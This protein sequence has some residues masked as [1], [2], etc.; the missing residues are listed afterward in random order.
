MNE[1]RQFK[2]LNSISKLWDIF[3]LRGEQS[4]RRLYELYRKEKKSGE[5][6]IPENFSLC[7]FIVRDLGL[8]DDELWNEYVHKVSGV[9]FDRNIPGEVVR[10]RVRFEARNRLEGGELSDLVKIMLSGNRAAYELLM[11]FWMIQAQPKIKR[12]I[13]SRADGDDWDSAGFQNRV[14]GELARLLR[15]HIQNKELGDRL[16]GLF[17]KRI[18]FAL[19]HEV[20]FQQGSRRKINGKRISYQ[21]GRRYLS[22]NEDGP[23]TPENL[24]GDSETVRIIKGLIDEYS[25]R[26]R[27]NRK[28]ERDRQVL[29]RIYGIDERD[30]ILRDKRNGLEIAREFEIS[31]PRV[32]QI[33][34]KFERWV[35]EKKARGEFMP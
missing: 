34:G 5:I 23:S 1:Q 17:V 14:E 26:L 20:R 21:D 22:S 16:G 4:L 33:K 27:N 9:Q 12:F 6:K 18:R 19:L 29:F 24:A 3:N 10:Y 25:V 8:I 2:D 28:P 13:A 31:E 11:E 7:V 15:F 30:G 32:Y 35:R